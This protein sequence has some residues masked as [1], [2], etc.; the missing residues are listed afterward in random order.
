[1]TVS[2]V[3]RVRAEKFLDDA[4]VVC[5]YHTYLSAELWVVRSNLAMT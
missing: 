1:V 4:H 3:L 5:L 2:R